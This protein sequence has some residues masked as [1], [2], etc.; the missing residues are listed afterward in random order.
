MPDAPPS[1]NM[2]LFFILLRRPEDS[3]L[4]IKPGTRLGR[5]EIRSPIGSGGMERGVSGGKSNS[6]S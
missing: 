4:A 6:P 2:P 1:V 3:L 5:Y